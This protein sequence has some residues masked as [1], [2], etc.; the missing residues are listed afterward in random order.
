M[1]DKFGQI[2]LYVNDVESSLNFWVEMLEFTKGKTTND[3]EK[4][5]SVELSPYNNSDVDL[6]IFDK[7]FV[8]KNSPG[9]NLDASSILFSTYDLKDMHDRLTNKGVNVSEINEYQGLVHFT[10][11]DL[12]GNYFAVREIER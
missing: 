10:F 12:D 7:E 8:K 9:V 4:L 1:I 3:E 11:S 6:V 2:M 5:L